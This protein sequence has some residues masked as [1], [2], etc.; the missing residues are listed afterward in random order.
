LTPPG[1]PENEDD[2]LEE[3]GR[4][5]DAKRNGGSVPPAPESAPPEPAAPEPDAPPAA[6]ADAQADAPP[7]GGEPAPE[8]APPQAGEDEPFPG[9]SSLSPELQERV[10][11]TIGKTAAELEAERRQREK[12]TR[13]LD[14]TRRGYAAQMGRVQPLQR[15]VDRLRRLA[16]G[17]PSPVAKRELSLQD[18]LK[19]QSPERQAYFQRY[20]EDAQEQFEIA[21]SVV[22]DMLQDV[23]S[24]VSAELTQIRTKA[25]IARLQAAHPDFAQYGQHW[26]AARKQW[27]SQTPAAERY[28][29]WVD[30]QPEQIRSMAE[31][32]SADDIAPALTLFKWEEQNPEYRQTLALPEFARWRAAVPQRLT[33]MLDSP[34]ISERSFVLSSFWRDYQEA[35]GTQVGNDPRAA[36]VLAR[37]EQR[38]NLITPLPNSAAAPASSAA[39]GASEDA[40]VEGIWQQMQA[41]RQRG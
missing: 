10:R 35:Q 24:E 36:E 39:P 2:L 17:R 4:A 34:N 19:R 26:D 14:E 38:G 22:S 16:E 37:R 6:Q 13:S 23:R 1:Q 8:G 9:F 33:E 41:R 27:V 11:A 32:D 30:S 18:W 5:L 15:E 31:S 25:E 3:I 29:S 28:W 12:L 40:V 21:R 20:P 7:E